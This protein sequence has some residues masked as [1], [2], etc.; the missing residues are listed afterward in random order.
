MNAAIRAVVRTALGK[1]VKMKGI[2]QRISGTA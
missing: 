1:G 2:Q